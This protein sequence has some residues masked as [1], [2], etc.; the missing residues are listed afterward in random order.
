MAV[1]PVREHEGDTVEPHTEVQLCPWPHAL[2]M[3][4]TCTNAQTDK[5]NADTREPGSN[6]VVL[7]LREKNMVS[8]T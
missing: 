5:C 2:H 7:N 3:S 6:C 1:G 4:H 8:Q